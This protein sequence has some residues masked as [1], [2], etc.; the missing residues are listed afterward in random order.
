MFA[1]PSVLVGFLA[2][3]AT[4]VTVSFAVGIVASR[5]SR[6]MQE[7]DGDHVPLE[8]KRHLGERAD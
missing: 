7:A 1:L 3:G 6:D 2:L 8:I 4:L 5:R